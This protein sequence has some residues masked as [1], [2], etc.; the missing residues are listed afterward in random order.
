VSTVSGN[1]NHDDVYLL[2]RLRLVEE[3]KRLGLRD[4]RV[5]AALIDV[6]RHLFVPECLR[7]EAYANRA[8]PIGEDQTISQP[9]VVACMT[10]ALALRGGEKV[11]EIGTGSGYQAAVL[12]RLSREVHTVERSRGLYESARGLLA[13]LGYLTVTCHLGDGTQGL[14]AEAPFDAICVTAAAPDVPG[15][16]LE[17]LAEGGRLVIPVGSRTDQRLERIE[18]RGGRWICADLDRVVFVPLIGEHGWQ[19]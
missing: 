5:A 4:E 1:G 9:T 18:R 14:P 13:R 19:T 10:E 15:P 6:E 12:S 7:E 3:L 11:L 2:L 8:L 16:L 17:Q